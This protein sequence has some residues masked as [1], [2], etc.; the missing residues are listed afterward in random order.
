MTLFKVRAYLLEQWQHKK[1]ISFL[2]I[3][4]FQ[5]TVVYLEKSEAEIM[6]KLSLSKATVLYL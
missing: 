1:H 2:K 5:L 4:K 3:N 6:K